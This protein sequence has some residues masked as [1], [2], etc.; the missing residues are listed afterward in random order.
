MNV[1]DSSY[2]ILDNF[3]YSSPNRRTL[4]PCKWLDRQEKH[5]KKIRNLLKRPLLHVAAFNLS[6]VLHRE[7]GTGTPRGLQDLE[8][9]LF[10]CFWVVWMSLQSLGGRS[11]RQLAGRVPFL[12]PPGQPPNEA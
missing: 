7:T 8:A 11:G 3:Y 5:G 9:R 4:R 10:F 12:P 2:Y 1:E 6:L